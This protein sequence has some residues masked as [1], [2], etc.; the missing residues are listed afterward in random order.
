MSALDRIVLGEAFAEQNPL[1]GDW[2]CYPHG[3][4]GPAYVVETKPEAKKLL[5]E[6]TNRLSATQMSSAS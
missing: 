6:M 1:T 5:R 4:S 2:L 3:R